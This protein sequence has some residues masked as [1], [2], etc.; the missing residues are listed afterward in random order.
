MCKLFCWILAKL[1]LGTLCQHEGLSVH[2]G[3]TL[4]GSE[5]ILGLAICSRA[6]LIATCVQVLMMLVK[7]RGL[8]HEPGAEEE[9]MRFTDLQ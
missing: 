7:L 5:A 8:D 2:S 6:H 1:F 4:P 3:P 9:V